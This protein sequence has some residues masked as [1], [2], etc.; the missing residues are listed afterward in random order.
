MNPM[1]K[2]RLNVVVRA[3]LLLAAG[4]FFKNVSD[5]DVDELAGAVMTGIALVWSMYEKQT[6]ADVKVTAL[7]LANVSENAVR[8]MVSDP[9]IKTPPAGTP[10]NEVPKPA[11]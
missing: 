5:G 11:V 8:A 4:H 3:V 10:R 2:S 7:H 1:W 6:D 9:N